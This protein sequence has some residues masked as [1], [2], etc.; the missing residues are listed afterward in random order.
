MVQG[1]PSPFS[2][3]ESKTHSVQQSWL[4]ERRG[5]DSNPGPPNSTARTVLHRA[6]QENQDRSTGQRIWGHLW[7]DRSV[8]VMDS[9][10]ARDETNPCSSPSSATYELCSL[11][12]ATQPLCACPHLYSRHERSTYPL[13]W[14]GVRWTNVCNALLA[15]P[16]K[17][18]LCRCQDS[19]WP[20]RSGA[21]CPPAALLAFVSEMPA[22]SHSHPHGPVTSHS[23]ACQG[24]Y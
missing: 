3:E 4:G 23:K 11:R 12:Q 24:H 21:S 8:P 5:E 14:P 9:R 13:G 10:M 18:Q 22:P 2:Q 19:S 17:Y 16:Q 1:A 15:E 20:C 7:G 6:A